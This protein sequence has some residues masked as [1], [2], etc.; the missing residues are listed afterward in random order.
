[1]SM[2]RRWR[3]ARTWGTPVTASAI[4]SSSTTRQNT[5]PRRALPIEEALRW[6]IRDELPKRRNDERL[7]NL[8]FPSTSPMFK[9]AALGTRVDSWSKEPGMPLA[10]GDV[11]PD[12]E[13]I[14]AAIAAIDPQALDLDPYQIGHGLMPGDAV[15]PVLTS[16]RR[17]HVDQIIAMVRHETKAWLVTCAKRG[18]RPDHGGPAESDSVRGT[19][20]QVTLWLRVSTPAG[21][22]PDGEPWF[23]T[24]DQKTTPAR[25]GVY[26]TGTF[27]KLNWPRDVDA[28]AE[29][30]ARYAIWHAALT[31]LASQ[32]QDLRSLLVTAPAAPATPWISEP[33]PPTVLQSLIPA[34][35]PGPAVRT[36]PLR[37]PSRAAAPVRHLDPATYPLPDLAA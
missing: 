8:G 14:E 24:T 25:A 19:K 23:I 32:L 18:T 27:C 33:P 37:W 9:H 12:A 4:S 34:N 13:T 7:S 17:K 22:G 30:R 11:H 6:T 10:L 31:L 16:V 21:T 26:R 28:V 1:M 35:D 5:P 36:A 15:D 2:A 29:D 20:G 3:R